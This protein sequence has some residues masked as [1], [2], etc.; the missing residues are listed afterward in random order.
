MNTQKLTITELKA[1][2]KELAAKEEKHP[3]MLFVENG[4]YFH[5]EDHADHAHQIGRLIG[6]SIQKNSLGGGARQAVLE[7]HDDR[8]RLWSQEVA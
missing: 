1:H 2:I 5:Y 3:F 7:T 4:N 6:D 8:L